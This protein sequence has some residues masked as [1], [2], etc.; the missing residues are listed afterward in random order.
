MNADELYHYGIKGMKWGHRKKYYNSDGSMNSLGKARSDY[1]SAKKAYNKAYNSAYNYSS[2]HMIGQFIN[3]NKKAESDKRWGDAYDKAK[4]VNSAKNAYKDAKR[5]E[6]KTKLSSKTETGKR[7]VKSIA[8]GQKLKMSDKATVNAAAYGVVTV[9][10]LLN[11]NFG[12]AYLSSRNV[13][14]YRDAADFWKEAG[15]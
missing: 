14:R 12:A 7:I 2:R 11:G 10:H 6:R 8:R 1:K 4:A 9:Q 13:N 3:K 15:H 5:R